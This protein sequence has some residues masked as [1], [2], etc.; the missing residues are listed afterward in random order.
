MASDPVREQYETYP[1]PHRDPEE[2]RTRLLE[3]S[4]SNLLE[5]DHYLF[6]GRRDWSQPFRVLVAG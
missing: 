4:P 6:R 5:V 2:E 1:Y 3:G